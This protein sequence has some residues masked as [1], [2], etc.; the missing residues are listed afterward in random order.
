MSKLLMRASAVLSVVA[1]A[2]TYTGTLRNIKVLEPG[3]RVSRT[4]AG[5]ANHE[6]PLTSREATGAV[7]S[8][9]PISSGI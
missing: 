1:E 4:V 7:C 9:K 2:V 3:I 8:S 5:Y 6:C